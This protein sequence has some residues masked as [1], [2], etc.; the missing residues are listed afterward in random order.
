MNLTESKDLFLAHSTNKQRF[1][2]YLGKALCQSGCQVFHAKA[3]AD[4]LIVL[5][6][7]EA[8]KTMKT[9]Q[10]DFHTKRL[11]GTSSMDL[12]YL[13]FLLTTSTTPSVTSSLT[14]S[15]LFEI[16]VE[17]ETWGGCYE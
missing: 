6:A 17:L 1:I 9:D 8:A 14:S 4:L 12:N 13:L 3:D 16:A 7:V 11:L 10:E 2:D 5:K 15:L